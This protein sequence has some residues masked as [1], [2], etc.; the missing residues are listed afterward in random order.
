VGGG[1]NLG[2]TFPVSTTKKHEHY[3]KKL[4]IRKKDEFRVFRRHFR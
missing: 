4:E 3:G 1:R 2:L